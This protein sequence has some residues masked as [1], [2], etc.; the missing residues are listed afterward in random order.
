MINKKPYIEVPQSDNAC[1]EGWSNIGQVLLD[2]I[3]SVDKK[4]VVITIESNLG[5]YLDSNLH[6]LRDCIVPNV[7]CRA[8]DIYKDPKIIRLLNKNNSGSDHHLS[9]ST[10]N[11]ED[12]FDKQKLKGLQNNIDFIDE[13]IVLIHGIGSSKIWEP[14]ILIYS[15]ISRWEQLQRFRRGEVSNIGVYNAD[16]PH[17][18][19]Q[20]WS[21][22]IDW[23]ICDK[24]KKKAITSCDYFLET[25]NWKKPKL[26]TGEIIRNGYELAYTQPF[27]N[28]PF[29]DPELWENETEYNREN[30]DFKWGFNCS[31]DENNILLKLGDYLFESPAINLVYFN[32]TKL[33]G[34]DV[35]KKYGHE[36]PI[37]YNFI[38]TLDE[39]DNNLY[40]NPNANFLKEE[41]GIHHKQYESYYVMDAEKSASIGIGLQEGISKEYFEET[42]LAAKTKNARNKIQN[43]LETVKLQ[44]HD[45]LVIP[46]DALHT[47]GNKL[48]ILSITKSSSIFE[49]SLFDE[50]EKVWSADHL[51]QLLE[52]SSNFTEDYR[53]HLNDLNGTK[54]NGTEYEILGTQ[55]DTFI[56]KRIWIE[57]PL[58]L[59]TAGAI[60]VINLVEGDEMTVKGDFD[61]MTVH[62]AETFVVPATVKSFMMDPSPGTRAC[63]LLTTI[64][65]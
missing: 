45:H 61:P 38:D 59:K 1:W 54:E 17:Q 21:Y 50:K 4:K 51:N 14:D 53:Q 48:M 58:K 57:K 2:H 19:Q 46:N 62:Y 35:Y 7:T 23:R 47:K 5:T 32:P 40:L 36:L 33:L 8:K 11:I 65:E 37:R 43:L 9:T 52:F 39:K 31:M 42:T 49:L 34:D 26:A 41:Y 22:F 56:T 20:K 30:N 18:K 16:V 10:H 12:Y 6:A 64:K 60:S 15:D 44:K 3:R 55:S 28:A 24:I 13:G 29:F 27:F 25:N 63:L